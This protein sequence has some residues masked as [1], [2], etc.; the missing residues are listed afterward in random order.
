MPPFEWIW[1]TLP[2]LGALIGWGTNVLAV[3]LLFRPHR[4]LRVL[5]VTIQGLIP[6]RRKEL[7]GKIAETGERE[8]LG[9]DDLR[10]ALSAPE[11]AEAFHAEIDHRVGDFIKE[12]FNGLPALVLTFIPVD[13]EARLKARVTEEITGALP[14]VAGR[15]AESVEEHLDVRGIVRER[16]E[17]FSMEKL[18]TI[19]LDIAR[20]ELFTIEILGGVLGFLIGLAQVAVL[21]TVAAAG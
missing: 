10:A 19:V 7:A 14:S 15:L 6:R 2:V 9:A 3:R 17:G 20:R 5:G 12:Q 4:P 11:L 8:F 21:W 18:E 13:L 1:L 16:I